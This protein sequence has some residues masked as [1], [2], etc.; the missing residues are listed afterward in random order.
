ML[1]TPRSFPE[2]KR[3]KGGKARRY[4][5]LENLA[6]VQSE[7]PVKRVTNLPRERLSKK[8]KLVKE[9]AF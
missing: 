7:A 9:K 2:A 3:K 6:V 4:V 5:L 8:H 1:S